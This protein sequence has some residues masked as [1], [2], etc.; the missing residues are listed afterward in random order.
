MSELTTKGICSRATPFW[1]TNPLGPPPTEAAGP[2]TPLLDAHN[3]LALKGL[4]PCK[5]DD[6]IMKR[7]IT[8]VEAKFNGD[9]KLVNGL[10]ALVEKAGVGVSTKDKQGLAILNEVMERI[11]I[12]F[13]T[14]SR[15][16]WPKTCFKTQ[17]GR[18]ASCTVTERWSIPCGECALSMADAHMVRLYQTDQ[19]IRSDLISCG[20]TRPPPPPPPPSESL[21]PPLPPAPGF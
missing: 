9:S 7:I 15:G 20:G 21:L 16:R 14:G 5:P 2:L 19:F 12:T 1:D 11:G 6:P 17:P 8:E 4:Q 13:E 10:K 18:V 3:R